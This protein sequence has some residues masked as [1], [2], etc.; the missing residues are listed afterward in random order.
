MTVDGE[1][2][3]QVALL[4]ALEAAASGEEAR[5]VLDRFLE[6]TKLHFLSEELLMRLHGYP[7]HDDHRSEHHR[8]LEEL[9]EIERDR[10]DRGGQQTAQR[11]R[12]FRARLL[13]H[14]RTHDEE[15]T[16]YI[17]GR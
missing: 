4:E 17:G 7:H 9:E 2:R 16:R 10:A 14:I 11:V 1:H 5:E 8:M 13:A 15:L 6:Y 3:V 12:S